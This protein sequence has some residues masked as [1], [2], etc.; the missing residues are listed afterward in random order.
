MDIVVGKSYM[1]AGYENPVFVVGLNCCYAY[2]K[3]MYTTHAH[4]TH[5][6]EKFTIL[7][8]GFH[9]ILLNMKLEKMR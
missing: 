5:K 2:H 3:S 7:L 9:A 8:S 1:V 6:F 4:T